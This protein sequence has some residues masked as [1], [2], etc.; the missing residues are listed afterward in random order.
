M[1]IRLEKLR[2]RPQTLRFEE[3]VA[4]FP[5]L[6]Q[7]VAQGSLSFPGGVAVLLVAQHVSAVV[8]I[9]GSLAFAVVQPCSRCLQP[10]AEEVTVP[11][12]LAFSR[13]AGVG[14]ELPEELELNETDLGLLEFEGETIDLLP[15]LEQEILMSLPQHPLCRAECRGLCPV[16]GAD[17]NVVECG[18]ELPVFN[19]AL[20]G[21]KLFKLDKS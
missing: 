3:P 1:E 21:L 7:L 17:L 18:C 9:E 19:G 10:V 15:A 11:V 5:V 12:A 6:S 4:A 13:A 2:D 16:C 20:A 8:E 14:T